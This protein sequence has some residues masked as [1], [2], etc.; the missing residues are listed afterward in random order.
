MY[1]VQRRGQ[2]CEAMHGRLGTAGAGREQHRMAAGAQRDFAQ[3]RAFARQGARPALAAVP[4][5][6][7][8]FG[9]IQHRRG[10]RHRE[11]PQIALAAPGKPRQALVAARRPVGCD[12]RVVL[13]LTTHRLACCLDGG[14]GAAQAHVQDADARILDPATGVQ[15]QRPAPPLC[16]ATQRLRLAQLEF[17]RRF[18]RRHRQHLQARFDDQ[19][20]RAERA[21]DQARDVVAR[22]VLHHLAA[23]GQQLAAAVDHREPEHVVAHRADAGARGAGQAR[24]H[25][26]AEGSPAAKVRRLERQA[27]ALAREQRFQFGQRRAGAHGDDELTRLVARDAGQCRGFEQLAGRRFAVE[28]LAAAAS[29]AQARAAACGAAHAFDDLAEVGLHAAMVSASH[30]VGP[31]VGA[32]LFEIKD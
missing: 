16:E 15:R 11:P 17:Q 32:D 18:G 29:D 9:Q 19:A 22:D 6:E 21:G 3:A 12:P 8:R 2:R 30:R 28:V 7:R 31:P 13:T 1:A 14:H 23:E 24:R 5:D 27:L 25:H 4:F 20:Q 10:L 26:P